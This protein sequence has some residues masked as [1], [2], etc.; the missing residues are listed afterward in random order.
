MTGELRGLQIGRL[1]VVGPAHHDGKRQYWQC[2]CDCGST[3]LVRQDYLKGRK[4]SCGCLHREV[5]AARNV[6]HGWTGTKTFQSWR[7]MRAR[8]YIATSHRFDR[9]G[10]RGIAVCDRWRDSFVAFLADMGERPAGKT[11]DRINND[12]NYEPGNCRWATSSEQ[13]R[14]RSHPARW[15]DGLTAATRPRIRRPLTVEEQAA[16]DEWRRLYRKAF[17]DKWRGRSRTPVGTSGVESSA[18]RQC[19]TCTGTVVHPA[20]RC[21]ACKESELMAA[22]GALA[23]RARSLGMTDAPHGVM[24]G[25]TTEDA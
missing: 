10:G 14:N 19:V 6:I 25:M 3:V 2:A 1:T 4:K 5:T 18:T 17:P 13:G 15:D 16:K 8:C 12:G 11:L 22:R 21:E 20:K 9:Y 23:V 24:C 7:S